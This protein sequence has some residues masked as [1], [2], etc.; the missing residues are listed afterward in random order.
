[1][2]EFV[3]LLLAAGKGARF[4]AAGGAGSKLLAQLASG[5]T[6]VRQ[7]CEN[8]LAA[9]WPVTVVVG[10]GDVQ[11]AQALQGLPVRFV[12]VPNVAPEASGMAVSLRTGVLAH[13]DAKAWLIALS[14]MPFIVPAISRQVMEAVQQGASVAYPVCGQRRGHPVAFSRDHFAEL[15]ALTGDEGARQIIR[16]NQH[17]AYEIETESLDVLRDIDLPDDLGCELVV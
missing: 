12:S 11:I 5:R 13:P 7:S 17:L 6:V 1:M 4:N 9:G 2:A 8:L 15:A 10:E 16:A 3:A 14:D